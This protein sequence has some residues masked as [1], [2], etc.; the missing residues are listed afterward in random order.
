MPVSG[1]LP[2]TTETKKETSDTFRPSHSYYCCHY[3]CEGGGGVTQI[4]AEFTNRLE[5]HY[6]RRFALWQPCQPSTR[7]RKMKQEKKLYIIYIYIRK[8][9]INHVSHTA[10]FICIYYKHRKG[11][12]GNV[13]DDKDKHR[14]LFNAL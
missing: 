14:D 10:A 5:T 4:F 2:R 1:P 13:N 3:H 8:N 6:P 7:E 12:I 9:N 11:N